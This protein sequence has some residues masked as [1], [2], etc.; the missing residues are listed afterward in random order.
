MGN[1]LHMRIANPAQVR[2]ARLVGDERRVSAW[3]NPLPAEQQDRWYSLHELRA[4]TGVP[5]SRLP[6]VLHRLGWHRETRFGIAMFHGPLW[7]EIGPAEQ[8]RSRR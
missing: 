4:A 1:V 3:F 5:M 2:V 7:T 8:V 6:I